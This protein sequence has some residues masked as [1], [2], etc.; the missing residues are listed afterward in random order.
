M[1]V[2]CEH[3]GNRVPPRYRRMFRGLRG[4]LNTHRGYDFGALR[5]ARQLALSFAAPLVASQVTRLLVDLNRSSHHPRLHS[6]AV[7]D[8]SRETREKIIADYYLPYRNEVEHLARKAIARGRRVIHI[9][10]HSFTPELNGKRRTADVGLLYDPARPGEVLL[11][12]RWKTALK[13]A[14]PESRVRRNY[15]Y[16]GKDDGFMPYLRSR[17][18]PAQYVGIELEVNQ[19]IIVGAPRRWAGLRAAIIASLRAALAA[20]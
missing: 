10:A 12:E 6:P 1:L 14:A 7:R 19:A 16:A 17:Y 2:T 13:Q 20:R 5:M 18:R 8:A 11:G 15:P 3:G 9:S 4:A